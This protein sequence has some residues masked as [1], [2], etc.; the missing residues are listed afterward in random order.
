MKKPLIL[1]LVLAIVAV[2]IC[3][4]QTLGPGPSDEQLISTMMTD[5]KAAMKTA[6]LN[7]LMATYSED[8]VSERGDNKESMRDWMGRAFDEGVMDSVEVRIEDAQITIKGDEAVF[9][10]V[11]FVSDRGKF[12]LDY[13]LRKENG[14]WLI[15]GSENQNQ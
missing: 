10:P 11:E 8:Y 1:N 3:G 5:W 4:C 15:A 2:S 9:G 7:Q 13:K 6:D 12:V 14:I